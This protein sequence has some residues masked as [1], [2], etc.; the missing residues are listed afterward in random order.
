M[1][2]DSNV[3]KPA[4]LAE[5]QLYDQG[6][7]V[8]GNIAARQPAIDRY[9]QSLLNAATGGPSQLDPYLAQQG[10]ANLDAQQASAISQRGADYAT[11][12]RNAQT[13]LDGQRAQ[14]AQQANIA[15]IQAREG[16]Q[17]AMSNFLRSKEGNVLEGYGENLRNESSRLDADMAR[18]KSHREN[19]GRGLETVGAI[20]AHMTDGF[21][22]DN[23]ESEL[24]LDDG[25]SLGA[26]GGFQPTDDMS[27][28]NQKKDIKPIKSFLDNLKAYKYEY[29]NP[30][31]KGAGKG[32]HISVMAQDLEKSDIG[33]T[34]VKNT[35]QGKMVNYGKGYAVIL[36]AQADLN[37][38][39]NELEASK[40][41]KGK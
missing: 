10:Q 1:S 39:L 6:A 41:K 4:D 9:E 25:P 11:L 24:T 14:N 35:P 30:D 22:S 40:S 19:V 29:K 16:A 13:A 15:R 12:A 8:A 32:E 27:D 37:K 20:G 31:I 23:F 38:R 7:T 18:D 2:G 26:R 5:L 33:K 21:G 3:N 17:N 28:K 36:A 34:M